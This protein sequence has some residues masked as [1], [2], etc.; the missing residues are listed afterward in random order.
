[1]PPQSCLTSSTVYFARLR[2]SVGL[3]STCFD[4]FSSILL[5]RTNITS[6][7]QLLPVR[8][9]GFSGI[10]SIDI[11]AK[12]ELVHSIHGRLTF[13]KRQIFSEMCL[14]DNPAPPYLAVPELPPIQ[15]TL[16]GRAVNAEFRGDLVDGKVLF[17]CFRGLRLLLHTVRVFESARNVGESLLQSTC[18][19]QARDTLEGDLHRL[20]ADLPLGNSQASRYLAVY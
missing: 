2:S 18:V 12:L 4:T 10:A 17:N 20:F 1:M 3:V 9:R 14:T 6:L 11:K 15:Q 13:N 16:D 5:S 7:F 19:Q 8:T